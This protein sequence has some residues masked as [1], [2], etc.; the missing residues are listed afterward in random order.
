ML[1]FIQEGI[2]SRELKFEFS[3][4]LECMIAEINLH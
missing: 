2:P 1:V 4:N 3:I